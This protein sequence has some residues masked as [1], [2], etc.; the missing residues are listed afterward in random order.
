VTALDA[1]II[2]VSYNTRELTLACLASIR[3]H[4]TGLTYEVIVV[5]NASTDGS[6]DAIAGACPWVVLRRAAT[7]L[8]FSGGVSDGLSV[9]RSEFII[10]FN[11]DAYLIDNAFRAMLEH[12]RAHALVGA[13]GCRVMNEDRSHQPTAAHFPDLWLDFSDH[14]L[15]PLRMLPKRW[16]RNCVDAEDYREPVDVD[17]VSGS[18]ALYRR[19]AIEAAGGID[20]DFFLGEEDIDLGYRLR[21]TGWR[22]VYLPFAG[23]VHLGGRSRAL[24][25]S[26]AQ[27]FFRGRY[28]FYKKHRSRSCA[29]T[30]KAMLLL[31]YGARWIGA[32]ARALFGAGPTSTQTLDRY[33]EYWRAIRR[34]Q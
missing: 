13:V 23:V 1:S 33:T 3:E 28:L 11:S 9:S 34:C 16:R 26:S 18:C 22:V 24:S 25:P 30:F 7:N 19:T 21:Q 31:A 8:G 17:W 10:L 14:L 2:V 29:R 5:D 20:D 32:R 15:R 27:H 4:T 6:A 12:A